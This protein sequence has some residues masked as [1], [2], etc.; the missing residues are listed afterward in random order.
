M[1]HNFNRYLYNKNSVIRVHNIQ[2]L[3]GKVIGRNQFDGMVCIRFML[4]DLVFG[5]LSP[6][7]DMTLFPIII[8]TF[9]CIIL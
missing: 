6:R 3:K 5:I 1:Y 7:F 4:D 9:F 8:N 2:P